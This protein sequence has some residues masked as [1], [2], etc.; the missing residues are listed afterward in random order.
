MP[1]FSYKFFYKE[2]KIVKEDEL[3]KKARTTRPRTLSIPSSMG[4]LDICRHGESQLFEF[5]DPRVDIAKIS[6]EIAAFLHTK[7]GGILFYG[8]EDDGSIV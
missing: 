7:N 1:K 6:K 4:I 5:K 3:Q 8:I 2:K